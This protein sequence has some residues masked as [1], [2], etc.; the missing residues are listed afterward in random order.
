MDL[1]GL[2]PALRE[3]VAEGLVTAEA[4]R[5]FDLARGPLLRAGLW[6]LDETEHLLLLALHHIVSDGWSLGVL[7]REVTALYA[8]F[9]EAGQPSPLAELPVQYADFAAWQR[10][11]LS[12]ERAGRRS[13]QHWRDHLAGAP[14][15]LELPADR[16]R[17]AVQSFRGAVRPVSLPPE[18]SRG[19]R[20][21]LPAGGSDPLH[22]AGRRLSACCCRALAGQADLTLGTPVA[23]RRHLETESLIGFFVNT[24]VLRPDLSG[25]PRFTELLARVRR[26]ALGRLRAS[27]PAVRKAG[28]G[29]GSGAE[30][31]RMRRCSR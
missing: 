20:R 15:V 5:P 19:S 14:P 18:L 11:W 17:P 3:P 21:P 2:A 13:S 9:A 24:L 28:R 1:T 27:G 25:E 29:S 10:S 30:P 22:D 8:A 12:G 31:G 26:E 7:V 4:R 6:R 16:P 23:G